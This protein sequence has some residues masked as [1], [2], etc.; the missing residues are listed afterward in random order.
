MTDQGALDLNDGRT[1]PQFGLGVWQVPD[2]QAPDV[3]QHAIQ[4]G[5]RLVD[6]A[7]VY[8]NEEGVGKA[9]AAAGVA[10]EKLFITT[11]LANPDHGFDETL[12]AFDRSLA[13]LGLDYVDLYLIHWPRPTLNRYVETWRAFIRLREEGRVRSIGVSNFTIPHLQRVI[14]ETGIVPVVNQIELHPKFQQKDMRAFH[15]RHGIVTQSWSPLGRGRVT[16]DATITE[17]AAK[18]NKTWAQ[19]IIRWHLDSGLAVIPR[20]VSPERIRQNIDVFDF[21]LTPEDIARI[22]DLDDRE[23]RIGAHPDQFGT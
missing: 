13:R 2:D 6:T 1:M 17:L 15:T 21:Q 14:S 12:R 3:V 10:R 19:I 4:V 16:D 11:K 7:A 8:G 23:G 20:S 18:Y 9:L 22:D 5:Y